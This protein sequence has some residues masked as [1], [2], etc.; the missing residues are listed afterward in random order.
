MPN[1]FGGGDDDDED[2]E[3]LGFK[4]GKKPMA[5]LA[6]PVPAAPKPAA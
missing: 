2:E 4:F 6:M 1:L 5:K 3:D